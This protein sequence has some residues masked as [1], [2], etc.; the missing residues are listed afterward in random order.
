MRAT[1][2]CLIFASLF[3]SEFVFVYSGALEDLD[4]FRRMTAPLRKK[5]LAEMK[6]TLDLV[7]DTEYGNFP[8]DERLKCYFKCVLESASMMD[9]KGN[10]KFNFLKK[11]IPE[12]FREVGYEMIDSCTDVTGKDNCEIAYNFAKCTYNVN[13]V[14][15]IAP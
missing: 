10:I 11:M 8:E 4:S 1:E 3:V 13:P 2:F 9:K 7:E 14:A 5:C 6:I 12:I 15:Y